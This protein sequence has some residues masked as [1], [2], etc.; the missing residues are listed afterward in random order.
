MST[1]LSL[2]EENEDFLRRYT[3]LMVTVWRDE[4]EERKLLADPKAYAVAAGLPVRE[5]ATVLLDRSQTD[6]MFTPDQLVD[7]W[8]S[9]E[10]RHVLRVPEA[11]LVDLAELDE[12]ELEAV[13]GGIA[14]PKGNNVNIACVVKQ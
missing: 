11:P 6:G 3:D 5:G 4:D 14:P 8:N 1:N 10:N 9:V 12:R 13:A 7:D 2:Y